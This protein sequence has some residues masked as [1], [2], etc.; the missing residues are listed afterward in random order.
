[1]RGLDAIMTKSFWNRLTKAW[2]RVEV[3]QEKEVEEAESNMKKTESKV[4]KTEDHLDSVMESA[5]EEFRCFEEEMNRIC[6]AEHD[7]LVNVA[8]SERKMSK[9][10]EKAATFASNKY[11]EAAAKSASASMKTALKKVHPS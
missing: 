4:K 7:S 2:A 5:M 9:S 8:K 10:V 1:M 11:I 3:E 6:M